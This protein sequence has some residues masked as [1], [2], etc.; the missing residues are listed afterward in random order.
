[1]NVLLIDPAGSQTNVTHNVGLAYLSGSLS[2][3]G[4]NVAVLD[5]NNYTYSEQELESFCRYFKPD[6]IG[7]SVKTAL[8]A[9]AEKTARLLKR[10]CPDACFVVGGPHLSVTRENYMTQQNVYDYGLLGE[11]ERSFVALVNGDDPDGIP[12]LFYRRGENWVVNEPQLVFDLESIA[13][14]TY[15][16]WDRIDRS[17][18]S[19]PMVHSRGC[20]YHCSYCSVPQINGRKF[21]KRS[22]ESVINELKSARREYVFRTFEFIDDNFTLDIDHA[23]TVCESL[24]KADLGVGWYANNGIRADRLDAELSKLMKR[25]GCLGVAV[26]IESADEEILAGVNKGETLDD[27]RHGIS[28]LKKAGIVVGGHFIVG[29]PGDTLDKVKQSVQFKD[30]VGLDYAYF[31]QLVPYPGTKVYDWVNE[32]ATLLVDDVTNTAHFGGEIKVLMETPEFPKEE[33]KYILDL[34]ATD[35]SDDEIDDFEFKKIFADRVDLRVLLIRSGRMDP[36]AEVRALL[37]TGSQLDLLAPY[38]LNIEHSA[39]DK[40]IEYPYPGMMQYNRLPAEKKKQLKGYDI[41][42]YLNTV[43]SNMNFD[44]IVTIGQNC[45][46]RIFEYRPGGKLKEAKKSSVF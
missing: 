29:L 45:G 44:N 19:Y 39:L 13:Y 27:L 15:K 14:P 31:N 25:S 6:W 42:I 8:V 40:K 7:F 12:G 32:H 36:Y 17:L 10:V 21:R 37:P 3:Q 30:D 33:R 20:P 9:S 23:K 41:V 4:Y 16:T 18:F 5:L 46:K 34:L 1:M 43:Q 11:A 28:L 22:A 2:E 38:G 24:I 26:G 35:C